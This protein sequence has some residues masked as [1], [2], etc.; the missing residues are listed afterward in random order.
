[1]AD[2]KDDPSKTF[3]QPPLRKAL[4]PFEGL[5]AFDAI[6]R[7]GGVRKAA[8]W[9][10]RDHAVLSRHLRSLEEW[11]GITL[12]EREPTGLVLTEAG[13]DYHSS[14]AKALDM[15]AHATLDIL[16]QGMHHQ[17]P[18][19]STPGFAQQW[20]SRRLASLEK[21][22]QGVEIELK[23]SVSSPDFLSHEAIADIRYWASYEDIEALPPY[24]R[25]QVI[26]QSPIIPVAS[27]EYL[28]SAPKITKPDDLLHHQLLHENTTATWEVWLNSLGVDCA[29]GLKGPRLW[30]GNLTSDAARDGRGI[31]LTNPLVSAK[32]LT[33]G[34]LVWIGKDNPSFPPRM[35]DYVLIARH[36]RWNEPN[37]RKFRSWLVNTIAKDTP[38]YKPTA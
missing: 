9:L 2:R 34:D 14:I 33:R 29:G 10:D 21:A 11:V 6:A 13:K 23:P 7:L 35:G 5:R 24:L 3:Q 30:Q 28:E 8:K 19:W 38:E 18:I 27:P 36:D 12:V 22:N 32:H 20:L 37:L 31:T 17:L 25:S 1:M 4:P 26:A 16:N 15:V